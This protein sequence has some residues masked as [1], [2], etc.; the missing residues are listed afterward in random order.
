MKAICRMQQ[1]ELER[2]RASS[3]NGFDGDVV[4]D[5]LVK[6]RDLWRGVVLDREGGDDGICLIKL[7]DIHRDCWNVDTLF[8]L[9]E[10]DA[11]DAT[12]AELTALAHSWGAD[13]IDWM[14]ND[15]A[16]SVLGR[17]GFNSN[18]LRVWWD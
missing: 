4:V 6:H 7:R 8:I 9:C 11:S 18:L 14:D 1:L 3:F 10:D 16:N 17:G 12:R 13:E 2:I 5:S 15:R